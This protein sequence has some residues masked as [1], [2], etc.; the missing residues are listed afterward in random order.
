MKTKTMKLLGIL[1]TIGMLVTILGAF[2]LTA[3]AEADP[4]AVTIV[5]AD[6]NPASIVLEDA[7]GDGYYDIG[8]ADSLYAFAAA[9][10]GSNTAI[11]GELTANIT[12]NEDVLTESGE[13][14]ELSIKY[15]GSDITAAPVVEETAE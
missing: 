15:F 5:L 14:S 11:N 7:D 10:N 4:L 8:L 12:V 9:V 13:L 3:S 2:S 6:G 1:L